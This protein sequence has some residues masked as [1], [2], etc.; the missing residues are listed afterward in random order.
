MVNTIPV[1]PELCTVRHSSM[2]SREYKIRV[3]LHLPPQHINSFV[4]IPV[5][6]GERLVEKNNETSD[7]EA[8]ESSEPIK[9]PPSY[10]EAVVCEEKTKY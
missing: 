2:I 6:I 3:T 4:E 1:G 5:L 9:E 10:W 7:N 8:G